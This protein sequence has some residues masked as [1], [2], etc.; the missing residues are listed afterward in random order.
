MALLG[1]CSLAFAIVMDLF[2]LNEARRFAQVR[3][4]GINAMAEVVRIHT[5][6]SG[7][8]GKADRYPVVRF[9]TTGS[10]TVTTE[11]RWTKMRDSA[12]GNRFEIR[13]LPERPKV[14]NLWDG[15][16]PYSSTFWPVIGSILFIAI[17]ARLLS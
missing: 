4:R 8:T 6:R 13:Y 2:A 3:R 17:G 15:G 16:F 14:I 9:V 11:L 1:F 10:E 12:V 5:Y 7:T